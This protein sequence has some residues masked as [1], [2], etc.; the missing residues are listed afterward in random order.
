MDIYEENAIPA[1][2]EATQLTFELESVDVYNTLLFPVQ[3]KDYDFNPQVE[4]PYNI[5]IEQRDQKSVDKGHSP[6]RLDPLFT[7]QVFVSLQ[8]SPDGIKGEYPIEEENLKLVYSSDDVSIV[9]VNDEDTNI[10]TV[11]LKRLVRQ[12]ESGIWTVVGYDYKEK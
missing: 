10:T 4:V 6:W 5:E 9:E 2:L 8:I 1:F 7:T 12:D 11:Y 3:A